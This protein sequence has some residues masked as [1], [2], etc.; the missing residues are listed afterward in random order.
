MV[1]LLVRFPHK[2]VDKCQSFDEIVAFPGYQRR[3]Y[4]STCMH[5]EGLSHLEKYCF[6]LLAFPF[7]ETKN[8]F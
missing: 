6:H 5:S 4:V 2:K 3:K 1:Q 8:M 7:Q